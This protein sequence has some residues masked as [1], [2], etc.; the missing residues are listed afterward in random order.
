[1]YDILIVVLFVITIILILFLFQQ[2]VQIKGNY[3]QLY[4]LILHGLRDDI[5]EKDI[6][7][8]IDNIW[9]LENDLKVKFNE[10]KIPKELDRTI[11]R[12]KLW[13]QE[14]GYVYQDYTN[15]LSDGLNVEVIS[16]TEETSIKDSYIIRTLS[17]EI[18]FNGLF[19]RKS[20]VDV[21]YPS[22]KKTFIVTFD[23]NGG[24]NE[25][26]KALQ[27]EDGTIVQGFLGLT[28]G[29]RIFKGWRNKKTQTLITY[30][31]TI[32][33]H[34]ECVAEWDDVKLHYI[35][36]QDKIR[37][38]YFQDFTGDILY[39]FREYNLGTII[40]S[41]TINDLVNSERKFL[42]WKNRQD[43]QIVKFPFEASKHESLYSYFED[44]H[45]LEN[46]ENIKTTVSNKEIKHHEQE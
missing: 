36:N 11:Q 13:L 34:I 27:F 24:P 4:S 44:E 35:P 1:M 29:G 22:P 2:V 46:G 33:D 30:P 6:I 25:D 20:R 19:V 15:R 38:S 37:I 14:K 9:R 21:R 26:I 45:Q 5:S 17:P 39:E 3:K 40:E 43:N 16:R 28:Y 31:F 32:N 23:T 41:P 10:G 8:I 18:K 42:G 12:L 7:K